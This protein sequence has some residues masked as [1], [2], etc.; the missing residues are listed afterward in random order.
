MAEAEE[1]PLLSYIDDNLF[2][3]FGAKTSGSSLTVIKP[4]CKVSGSGLQGCRLQMSLVRL[5]GEESSS[6]SA[7]CEAHHFI[8]RTRR[9]RLAR[10][11]ATG[12]DPS[13]E[14]W[15]EL[16]VLHLRTVDCD[17]HVVSS[18]HV[19]NAWIALLGKIAREYSQQLQVW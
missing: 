9:K 10:R 8:F 13:D 7:V 12:A 14:R 17:N 3:G 2:C 18:L 19:I 16:D 11:V 6:S 5:L 4:L 15:R 1:S